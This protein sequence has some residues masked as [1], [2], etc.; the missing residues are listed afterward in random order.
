MAYGDGMKAAELSQPQI[1]SLR[2]PCNNR[3]HLS[4]RSSRVYAGTI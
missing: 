4:S 1:W 3:L 2:V